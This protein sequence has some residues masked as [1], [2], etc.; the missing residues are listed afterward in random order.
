MKLAIAVLKIT[1][2][3]PPRVFTETPRGFTETPRGITEMP[4]VYTANLDLRRRSKLSIP[5]IIS[6]RQIRHSQLALRSL[7]LVLS[8]SYRLEEQ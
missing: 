4:R 7:S 8:L 2:I 5:Q 6:Q 1:I 3:I